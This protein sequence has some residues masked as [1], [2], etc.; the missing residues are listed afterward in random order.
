[1]QANLKTIAKSF[2]RLLKEIATSEAENLTTKNNTEPQSY[3][4]LHRRD[5]LELDFI[6]TFLR[7]APKN[8]PLY[9]LTVWDTNSSPI[10][11]HMVLRGSPALIANFAPKFLELLSGKGGGGGGNDNCFQGKVTNL[12]NIGKCEELLQEYFNRPIISNIS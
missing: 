3:F 1:M 10:R 12:N 2:Q 6:H 11:G 5:G 7:N 4:S 9:F 8:I